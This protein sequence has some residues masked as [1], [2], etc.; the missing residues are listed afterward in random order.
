MLTLCGCDGDAGN[1][2]VVGE[3]RGRSGDTVILAK[4]PQRGRACAQ[5]LG[6]RGVLRRA[7]INV[8]RAQGESW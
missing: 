3:S 7:V 4:A 8:L 6:L 5:T 2:S 1:D